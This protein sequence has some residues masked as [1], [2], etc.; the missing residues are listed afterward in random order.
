MSRPK[1]I[2]LPACVYHIICRANRN[3]VVFEEEKDK[4][5]FLEYFI[6]YASQFEIRV[7]AWCLMDTHLHLLIETTKANL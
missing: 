2:N 6:E 1:R 5:R 7:H 4:E 3:D